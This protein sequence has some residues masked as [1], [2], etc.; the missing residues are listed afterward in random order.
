MHIPFS[1]SAALELLQRDVI[2]YIRSND[3]ASSKS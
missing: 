3:T 2:S 1:C